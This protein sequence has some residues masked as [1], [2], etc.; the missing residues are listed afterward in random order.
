VLANSSRQ[1]CLIRFV[2]NIVG[3]NS[4]MLRPEFLLLL[5]SL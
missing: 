3:N 4:A 1:T 2:G 5:L